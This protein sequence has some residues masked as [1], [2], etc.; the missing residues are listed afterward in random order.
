[1]QSAVASLAQ[2]ASSFGGNTNKEIKKG[3][4]IG[5]K[6]LASIEDDSS[7]ASNSHGT[8]K[9]PTLDDGS[10]NPLKKCNKPKPI[11]E[12]EAR[13]VLA[14][15]FGVAGNPES[16]AELDNYIKKCAKVAGQTAMNVLAETL[17]CDVDGR[18]WEK[19]KWIYTHILSGR[20]VS[21]L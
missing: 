14:Q 21:A 9:L 4:G 19:V 3:K 7:G 15:V 6:E 2:L 17:G 5:K 12:K 16:P 10:L 1:M 11:S 20:F 8:V 18:V 13:T